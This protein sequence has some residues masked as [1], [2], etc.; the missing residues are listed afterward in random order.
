MFEK[1]TKKS[2]YPVF[3]CKEE[4]IG[5]YKKIGEGISSVYKVEWA[6]KEYAGKLY[7]KFR[8]DD[9]LYELNIAKKLENTEQSVKVYGIILYDNNLLILMEL[10]TSF[11]DLYD[12]IQKKQKWKATYLIDG[13][14][15]PNPKTEYIYFNKD[16]NIYW[17]YILSDKQKMKI[18]LSLAK[19]IRELH[20]NNII[21]GDIKTN[22]VVLHYEPKKEY[23][24]LIDFG[25][26]YTTNTEDL[27]EIECRCGTL[28]YRAPEQED[29]KM[30]YKSDIYSMAVTIV[31]LWN[32]DIWYDGN[33]F[34][35]CRKEVLRGIRNI[36]KNN[37]ELGRLI[38][39]SINLKHK[40]R[41]DSKG[42][43]ES[44][45]KIISNNGHK[46]RKNLHN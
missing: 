36:E 7:E 30:N 40:N 10:L 18:T 13:E 16:D 14:Y 37:L 19:A 39:K 17:N 8:E 31:E 5:W 9:I 28:G 25:V 12:Y 35:E 22:N 38:R 26:S 34:K 2:P 33:N 3:E 21:H 29:L 43:L 42:F 15:V 46:Y 27:I 32:G 4:D 45:K 41:P 1:L 23:I 44:I 6:N 20:K 24:K 11:G